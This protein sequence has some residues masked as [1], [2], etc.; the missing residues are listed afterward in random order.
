SQFSDSGIDVSLE[1]IEKRL[2]LLMNEYKVPEDE[3]KRT[4][5]NYFISKSGAPKL[6]FQDSE[7]FKVKDIKLEGQWIGMRAKVVQLWENKHDSISQVGLLGDDTGTIKFVSWKKAALPLLKEGKSYEFKSVVTDSYNERFSV[8]FNHNTKITELEEE[9]N[10]SGGDIKIA[11]MSL[12]GQWINLKAKVLQLWES[13]HESIAQVGLLG[14]ESGT[15]KFT[16]WASSGLEDVVEGKSYEFRN[17][18]TDLWQDRFN[19]KLN[20]NSSIVEIAEDIETGGTEETTIR[21]AIVSILDGSGLIKRCNICNRALFEGSCS[22]HGPVD[23]T[24]DLRVKGVIDDGE[25]AQEF[26][27]NEDAVR[28][29]CGIT[30]DEAR[31]M[32]QDAVLGEIRDKLLGRY[33]E[34]DGP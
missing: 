16:I 15:V 17:V 32:G 28:K 31:G 18:I 1:E 21:G 20:R 14:D 27:L 34:V 7:N 12:E 5:T 29:A 33:F 22:E 30:L 3:A 24:D 4:V 13:N 23:G 19:V 2:D 26:L 8:K 11:D 10:T 25:M 9:V 6:Q